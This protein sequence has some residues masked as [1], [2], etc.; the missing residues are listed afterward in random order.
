M[1]GHAWTGGDLIAHDHHQVAR[2]NQWVFFNLR[3]CNPCVFASA[4]HA[5]KISYGSGAMN[6]NMWHYRSCACSAI[7]YHHAVRISRDCAQTQGL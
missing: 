2:S 4:I 5:S 1:H 3:K 6:V 7:K